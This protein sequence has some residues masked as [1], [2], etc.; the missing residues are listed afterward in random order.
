MRQCLARFIGP[1]HRFACNPWQSSSP[2]CPGLGFWYTQAHGNLKG[3]DRG[4][5]Y[6]A[7]NVSAAIHLYEDEESDEDSKIRA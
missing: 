1:N 5:L 4:A 7:R 3:R 2:L 6:T